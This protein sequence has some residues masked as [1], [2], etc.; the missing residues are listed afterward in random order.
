MHSSFDELH[1]LLDVSS[2]IMLTGHQMVPLVCFGDINILAAVFVLQTCP[3]AS[4]P[5]MQQ[6][7]YITLM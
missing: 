4:C 1:S 5:S 3:S 7:G 2:V 6:S